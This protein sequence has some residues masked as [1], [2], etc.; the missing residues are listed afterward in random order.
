MTADCRYVQRTG[1]RCTPVITPVITPVH[2]F[3]LWAQSLCSCSSNS[4]ICEACPC[5]RAAEYSCCSST[6]KG[7]S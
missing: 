7:G 2:M 4:E 6:L 3:N 1:E 5:V